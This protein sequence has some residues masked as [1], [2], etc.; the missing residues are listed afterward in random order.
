MRWQL[1]GVGVVASLWATGC[2]TDCETLEVAEANTLEVNVMVDGVPGGADGIDDDTAT[3]FAYFT[4]ASE[5]LTIGVGFGVSPNQPG[6]GLH[7]GIF[8]DE[9]APSEITIDGTS[10]AGYLYAERDGE[11]LELGGFVTFT[12][13]EVAGECRD[14]AC[15]SS[16]EGTFVLQATFDGRVYDITG[17]LVDR[18]RLEESC[19]SCTLFDGCDG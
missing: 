10:E 8:V 9:L 6:L 5:R 7:A 14:G 16:V 15:A 13:A 19:A 3:A 17:D 4:E 12:L 2:Q 18:S 11:E 1:V